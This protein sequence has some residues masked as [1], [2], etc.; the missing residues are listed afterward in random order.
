MA[1]NVIAM[2]ERNIMEKKGGG[3][4]AIEIEVTRVET[5]EDT[6]AIGIHLENT[7]THRDILI[8]TRMKMPK[9]LAM[10]IWRLVA[11]LSH[12]VEIVLPQ[13][14]ETNMPMINPED[15]ENVTVAAAIAVI[16]SVKAEREKGEITGTTSAVDM[17]T[18]ISID[19]RDV[20]DMM[21]GICLMKVGMGWTC[22]QMLHCLM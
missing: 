15:R 12:P 22:L 13:L 2:V 11:S 21:K 4:I 10:M 14:K 20:T 3:G 1:V 18:D 7:V 17:K 19:Q 8:E 16:A 6:R 5:T 9:R